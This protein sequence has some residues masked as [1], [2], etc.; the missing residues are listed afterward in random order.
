MCGEKPKQ[1]KNKK[2]R[3]P[4]LER[5]RETDGRAHVGLWDDPVT[6]SPRRAFILKACVVE[7]EAVKPNLVVSLPPRACRVV[8]LWN[9]RCL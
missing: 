6:D 5:Q 3:P 7:H 2:H 4:P 1:L 8:T 9:R